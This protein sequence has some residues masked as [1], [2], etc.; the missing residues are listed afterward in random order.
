MKPAWD[1]LISDF[2]E[3]KTALVADVDCTDSGKSLCEKHGVQGYPTIKWG[4]PSDLQKY[5]GG[6]D[7]DSLKKFA[8]ENLGPTCG[9]DNLDLC[10]EDEKKQIKKMSKMDIDELDMSIE[11]GEEKIKKLEEKYGKVESKLKSE[12]S[13]LEDK[14]AKEKKKK[15][16][17]IAKES[18]K[19]GLKFMKAIAASKAPQDETKAKEKDEM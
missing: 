19:L 12:I 3:S 11:E 8:E 18:K 4:D 2:A 6:R 7:L 14:I 9:P 15:D 1:Q 17:S 13:A 5:E 10:D 16:A